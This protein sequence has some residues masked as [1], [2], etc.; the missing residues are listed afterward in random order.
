[1]AET[2][3]DATSDTSAQDP[4]RDERPLRTFAT[5]VATVV[6]IVLVLLLWRG[7][8]ADQERGIA[9]I[10]DPQVAEIEG[11]EELDG[12]VAVW[13][14]PDAS[15]V[16]VLERNGLAGNRHTHLGEGTYVIETAGENENDIVRRLE[17][18]P[19]LYDA[20]FIYKE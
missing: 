13:L 12:S 19:G 15:I 3:Y 6:V 16:E 17:K 14:R 5:V 4:K 7:C 11:L 1:M 10:G 2:S 20:G 18:D 8:A 9:L